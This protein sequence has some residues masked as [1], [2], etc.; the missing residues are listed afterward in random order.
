MNSIDDELLTAYADDA[1]PDEERRR[2]EALLQTDV[3]ARHYVEDLTRTAE[4]LRRAYAPAAH[5]VVPQRLVAAVLDEPSKVVRPRA[6]R[7]VSPR[8]MTFSAMAASLAILAVFIGIGMLEGPTPDIVAVG[9]LDRGH[10]LH[11]ALE[12]VASGGTA[13]IG[14]GTA[15]AMALPMLTFRDDRGRPCRELEIHQQSGQQVDLIIACRD[16]AAEWTVEGVFR[17]ADG[18]ASEEAGYTPAAGSS[19]DGSADRL[20]EALGSREPLSPVEEQGLLDSG[21]R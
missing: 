17:L 5:A 13:T 8:L 4:V 2:V 18:G 1:L 15:P 14:S 11:H 20:L 12:T 19:P 3:V 7:R 10:A 21:W 6:W 9:K 16:P